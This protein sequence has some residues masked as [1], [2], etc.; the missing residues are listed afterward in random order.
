MSPLFGKKKPKAVAVFDV[1]SGSIAS[2]LV[3]LVPHKKPQLLGQE[4][5]AL[6]TRKGVAA[7]ALLE[8]MQP[9]I[10]RSLAEFSGMSAK[11]RQEDKSFSG[12]DRI[13]F[14]MHAPWSGVQFTQKGARVD[15]HEHTMSSLRG[16]ASVLPG[17]PVTFHAYA[18]S[19]TPVV[20]GL[21]DAPKETL[22]VSIGGEVAELSLLSNG[23]MVSHATVPV[24]MHTVLRTLEA[25]GGLSRPEALSILS[26]DRNTKEHAWAEALTTAFASVKKELHEAA[27][28]MAVRPE[29]TQLFVLAPHHGDLF[30]KAIDDDS[31][32]APGAARSV[33]SKHV[34][35]HVD[36]HG[37]KPDI[38]LL[39]ESLF[40]DTRFGT[41]R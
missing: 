41:V 20:H 36:A 32:F 21:F 13:A 37:R 9:H 35:E 4:R 26:L 31:L 14:F 29:N 18:T 22:V 28:Q 19:I 1:E 25:H 10:E 12:I 39:L 3:L 27:S 16:P 8:Q 15:A 38:P 34:L 6:H 40:V 11:L 24:G 7:Q 30:A 33:H 5:T 17:V 2:G 23:A